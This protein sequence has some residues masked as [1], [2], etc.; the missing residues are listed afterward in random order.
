MFIILLLCLVLL[1]K[2]MQF[3]SAGVVYYV[4]SALFPARETFIPE[5]IFDDHESRSDEKSIESDDKE[6]G[7]ADAVVSVRAD[8]VV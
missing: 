3:S 4:L 6:K 5:A 1:D 7:D 8:V 2:K